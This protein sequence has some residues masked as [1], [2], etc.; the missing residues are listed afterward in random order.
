MAV[1]AVSEYKFASKDSMDKF[2]GNQLLFVGWDKHLMFY[3]TAA[4]PLPPT[5]KFSDLFVGPLAQ[6][7]GAHPDFAKIDW[8]KV[9]W[10][11]GNKPFQPDY[12]KS[13]AEN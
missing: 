3:G 8:S 10:L 2:H 5:M 12:D 9:T 11:N 13:L 6:S 7:Y 4:F 1:A